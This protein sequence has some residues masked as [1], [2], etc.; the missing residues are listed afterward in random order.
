MKRQAPNLINREGHIY[1]NWTIGKY[2][3]TDKNKQRHYE[4]TCVCGK[5]K[6]A[7]ILSIIRGF[8]KSCGCQ[9]AINHTT[10]GLSGNLMYRRWKDIKNRCYNPKNTKYKWY[11]D[12][13]IKMGEDWLNDPKKFISDMGNP[14]TKK[15]TIDRI[16]N[17]GNYEKNNCRWATMKEQA[18]NRRNPIKPLPTAP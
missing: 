16:D 8:S 13:G 10:H 6:I 9:N 15:H 1:N 12:R 18:N 17:N 11:G 2:M 5:F 3:F 14:P 7:N 4:A